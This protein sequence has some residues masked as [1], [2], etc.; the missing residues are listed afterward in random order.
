MM[1][2]GATLET[3]VTAVNNAVS[4]RLRL[5][6]ARLETRA[7]FELAATKLQ[8]AIA[9]S[10][11]REPAT[12]VDSVDRLDTV[13]ST[14]LAGSSEQD[15]TKDRAEY[16][17][18][19]RTIEL[20]SKHLSNAVVQAIK[21][22]LD[23]ARGENG[24]FA[25]IDAQRRATGEYRL[26]IAKA[27][28]GVEHLRAL[29]SEYVGSTRK[30]VVEKAASAQEAAT[31]GRYLILVISAASI[32]LAVLVGWLYIG[33]SLIGRLDR[34][35]AA[36]MAVANGDLNVAVPKGS[37]DEI[38]AMAGALQV[39]KD[40]GLEVAR[41]RIE[42]VEAERRSQEQ[43]RKSMLELA[44]RCDASVVWIVENLAGA[45]GELRD[46]AENLTH[47]A[48]EAADLS[49]GAARGAE[50]T[51]FNV[52]AMA[53]AV[54]ELSLTIREIT[55]QMGESARIAKGAVG[56]A[57]QTNG[58]VDGLKKAAQHVGDIVG[59]IDDIA[60]QTNLLALN[61]TIEA[62][63]A[64]EAGKGFAVV[65]SEVKALANQTAKA[66]E[67]I[68]A[69][70]ETMQRMTSGAVL[71]IDTITTTIERIDEISATVASAITQQGTAIDEMARNAQGAADA[72]SQVSE[73]ISGVS[74][75]SN[76]TGEAAAQVLSA[77]SGVTQ[78]AA[79]LKVEVSQFLD[80]VR[81]A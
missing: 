17:A 12:F 22:L 44:D 54:R 46:T 50:D 14:A 25:Q 79:R 52:Q 57:R 56:Q 7:A 71:A 5:A 20:Q 23:F 64:G 27:T 74:A 13:L 41:L 68:R 10:D 55:Q 28:Q 16:A 70:I 2:I 37:G 24:V 69:Q 35:V 76:R 19:E 45:S 21:P 66:T 48:Q 59:L 38:G 51:T 34:L 81:A 3:A 26:A 75:A 72:T 8:H 9:A 67:E 18:L 53:A 32:L 78:F 60:S 33:R 11:E 15:T 65:A 73:N 4:E 36:T 49:G 77:S 47:L 61:A 58:T 6:A 80:T 42:Q 30:A 29:L 1:D 63:R 39:F 31:T 40:N 62:A 43:R